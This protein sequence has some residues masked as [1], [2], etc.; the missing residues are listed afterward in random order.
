MTFLKCFLLKTT[1]NLYSLQSSYF[2]PD[3]EVIVCAKWVFSLLPEYEL[4]EQ[5]AMK[6]EKGLM[7]LMQRYSQSPLLPHSGMKSACCLVEPGNHSKKVT[8]QAQVIPLMSIF[9]FASKFIRQ[10][11]MAPV[12]SASSLCGLCWPPLSPI[13]PFCFLWGET[14]VSERKKEGRRKTSDLI[15]LFYCLHPLLSC[16]LRET[17][18]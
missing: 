11:G 9:S 8:C 16:G 4:K 10:E 3:N 6:W 17:V 13:F 18:P 12:H 15:E 14:D 5:F 7:K 1:H 2:W